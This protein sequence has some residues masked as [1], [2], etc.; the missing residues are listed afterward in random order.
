MYWFMYHNLVFGQWSF[1]T[2][3][4]SHGHARKYMGQFS[5]SAMKKFVL[6]VFYKD[7]DLA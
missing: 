6:N 3:H 4:D 1:K 5:E 2:C 7:P